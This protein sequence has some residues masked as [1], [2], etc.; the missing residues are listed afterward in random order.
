MNQQIKKR[1]LVE[2]RHGLLS[3]V[4]DVFLARQFFPAAH[5]QKSL[6]GQRQ[7]ICLQM[8]PLNQNDTPSIIGLA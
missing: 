6:C 8:I 2:K 5:I 1:L 4:E 3:V 7:F